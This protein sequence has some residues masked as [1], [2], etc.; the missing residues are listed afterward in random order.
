LLAL[1]LTPGTEFQLI[2][3]APLGDPVEIRVGDT[4]L[5]LRR[6]EV[7]ALRIEL[8]NHELDEPK[9]MRPIEEL[10]V[11]IIGKPNCGKTTLFNGLTGAR[12]H[13]FDDS[14]RVEENVRFRYCF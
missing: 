6:D 9:V 4:D 10:T 12:Q 14:S 3:V 1:G 13:V 11:A 5:S 7:T 8:Y 2:R